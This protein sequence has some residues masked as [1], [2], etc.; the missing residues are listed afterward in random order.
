[1]FRELSVGS[2]RL[3]Q[4]DQQS[5]GL[6]FDPLLNSY[7]S[8][9]PAP[10]NTLENLLKR[11][12]L[13]YIDIPMRHTYSLCITLKTTDCTKKSHRSASVAHGKLKNSL[14]ATD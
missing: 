8:R 1:M 10:F 3:A 2:C 14:S 12:L 13:F 7:L 5:L 4:R 6:K 11:H 9:L